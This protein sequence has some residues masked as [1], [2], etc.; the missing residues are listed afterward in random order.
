MN[1]SLSSR[2]MPSGRIRCSAL[3]AVV[4]LGA[5]L[6][7]AVPRAATAQEGAA[8]PTELIRVSNANLGSAA[9]LAR[10]VCQAAAESEQRNCFNVESLPADNM[11]AVTAAPEVIGRIRTL[12]A[13]IDKAPE[14]RSF[15]IV[16]LAADRSGRGTD[17]V[18]ENVRQALAD[19]RDFLPYTGFS[20][21]G[22]GWL[23][24]SEYG[25]ASLPGA[26]DLNA[27][28]R[29]SPNPDLNAPLLIQFSLFRLVP[30]NVANEGVVTVQMRRHDVVQS[31]FTIDRG[32]TVVVGTS[33]LDGGDTAMVVLLTAVQN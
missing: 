2:C 14:T 21:I 25:E 7:A 12:L 28:L 24:T 31:T 32:E 6:V 1:N 33:K 5:L 22:T 10:S 9:S 20:V 3:W 11:L 30:T 29:F 18:P 8:F 13:E 26:T 16:V 23:R 15:Q 17:E 27:A 4:L 19:V